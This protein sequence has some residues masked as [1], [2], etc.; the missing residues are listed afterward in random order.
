M[1]QP[2]K[3]FCLGKTTVT[4]DMQYEL[5]QDFGVHGVLDDTESVRVIGFPYTCIS[6]HKEKRS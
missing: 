1:T 4:L 3:A 2:D 6:V 5:V